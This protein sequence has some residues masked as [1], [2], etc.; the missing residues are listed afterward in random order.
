[1]KPRLSWAGVAHSGCRASRQCGHRSRDLGALGRDGKVEVVDVEPM[2]VLTVGSR[3][4][5]RPTRFAEL[6][7]R[8][9]AWLAQ[10]PEWEAAGP[11]RVMGYN[12]P[13]VSDE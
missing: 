2:T 11:L 8:L 9:E 10:S 7:A 13:M 4:F 12:S 5:D 6:K 3:G 1:M